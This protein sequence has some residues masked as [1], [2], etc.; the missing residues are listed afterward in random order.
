MLDLDKYKLYPN[1]GY[2]NYQLMSIGCYNKDTNT[3]YSICYQNNKWIKYT[4]DNQEQL[5]DYVTSDAY[6]LFYQDISDEP[7]PVISYK[8]ILY[9]SDEFNE[10]ICGLCTDEFKIDDELHKT[11][12]NHIY[13]TQCW[14]E[15]SNGIKT[16]PMCR[17]PLT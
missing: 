16:C 17:T 3:T 9:S 7:I 2:K 14:K 5:D 15:I 8:K 11:N 12:C 13:H 10:I 6:C 1:D 4:N